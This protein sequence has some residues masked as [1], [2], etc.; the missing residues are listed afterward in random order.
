MFRATMYASPGEITESVRHLVFITLC[1]WQSGM[2][3]GMHTRRS[4]AQW[5][6]PGVALIQL[7]L[8]MMGT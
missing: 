7:F 3:D 6:I 5:Q 2:Q 8:L 1:G 4:S